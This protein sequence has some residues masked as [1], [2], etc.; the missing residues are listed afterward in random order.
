M[1]PMIKPP[2]SQAKSWDNLPL[3]T[4]EISAFRNPANARHQQLLKEA[5]FMTFTLIG[6]FNM[7]VPYDDE[8]VYTAAT[9]M[10]IYNEQVPIS[11]GSFV[12]LNMCKKCQ[13]KTCPYYYKIYLD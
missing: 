11:E 13:M 3:M 1:Q 2:A 9:K 4:L 7:H 12:V 5:N 6:S 8:L 10:P